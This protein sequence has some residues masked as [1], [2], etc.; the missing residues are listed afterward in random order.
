M[1]NN[2]FLLVNTIITFKSHGWQGCPQ[3]NGLACGAHLAHPFINLIPSHFLPHN[4]VH[5]Q[6]RHSSKLQAF[7][8]VKGI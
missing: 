5:A 8:L 3:W 7:E 6:I 4:L 2:N 1:Y